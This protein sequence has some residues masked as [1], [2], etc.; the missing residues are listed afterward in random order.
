M[1]TPGGKQMKYCPKCRTEYENWVKVCADCNTELVY[2]LPQDP[3]GPSQEY[4]KYKELLSTFNAGDVIFIRSLL[5]SS[6]IIYYFN[7]ENFLFFRPA[8]EPARL[9]VDE[10]HYDEAKEILKEFKSSFT[11]FHTDQEK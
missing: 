11:S 4:I 5:D 2:E 7:G 6:G 3:A 9:M 10:R 8:V 1:L